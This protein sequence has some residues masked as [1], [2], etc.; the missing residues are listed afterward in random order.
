MSVVAYTPLPPMARCEKLGAFAL[1]EPDHGSDVVRLETRA[2]RDGDY[3]VL[4]GAKRWIGN[5]TIADLVLVWARDE[6]GHGD[7]GG[8]VVDRTEVTTPTWR[9][10]TRTKA[11]T[12]SNR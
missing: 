12:P 9:P 7:V 3:W 5:G 4:N 11:P 2:R 1:T 10:C 6:D 8:F